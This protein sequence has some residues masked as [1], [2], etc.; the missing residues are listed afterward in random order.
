MEEYKGWQEECLADLDI[1][2]E[3]ENVSYSNDVSPS[4]QYKGWQIYIAEKDI[5]KREYPEMVD[6][7]QICNALYYGYEQKWHTFNNFD[8]VLNFVKTTYAKWIFTS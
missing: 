5:S 1:P 3:W 4:Y 6:R 7:F 8:D 2:K